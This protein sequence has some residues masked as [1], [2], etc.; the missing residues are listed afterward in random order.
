MAAQTAELDLPVVDSKREK[1][2]NNL[3]GAAAR[4]RRMRQAPKILIS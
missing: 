4:F 3:E 1:Q 2:G